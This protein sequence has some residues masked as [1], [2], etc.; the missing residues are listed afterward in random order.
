MFFQ[1]NFLNFCKI[2]K[3]FSIQINIA[4]CNTINIV[5]VYF[6]YDIEE[7]NIVAEPMSPGCVCFWSDLKRFD[8]IILKVN[9]VELRHPKDSPFSKRFRSEPPALSEGME[10]FLRKPGN[11]NYT[12]F[13][14][15][16]I[17]WKGSFKIQQ[18]YCTKIRLGK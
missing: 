7:S 8:A 13:G 11:Y 12:A 3:I 5:I 17:D 16:R 15:G 2:I 18:D 1:V 14:R 6:L 10:C 4:L 9:N